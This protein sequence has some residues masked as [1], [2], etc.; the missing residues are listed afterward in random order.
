LCN[1]ATN[2]GRGGWIAVCLLVGVLAL[3]VGGA[4]GGIVGRRAF[5]VSSPVVVV[6]ASPS[7]V[8][9]SVPG[10]TKYRVPPVCRKALTLGVQVAKELAIA[11]GNANTGG[12]NSLVTS[13]LKRD[14][15]AFTTAKKACESWSG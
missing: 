10:P 13:I 7:P 1:D 3:A 11:W 12:S 4:A 6:S 8:Q 2:V 15:P 9:V 14:Y 5:P